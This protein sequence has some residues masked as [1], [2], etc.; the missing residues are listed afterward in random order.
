LLD[1]AKRKQAARH[2][3]DE[4]ELLSHASDESFARH[5]L[6]VGDFLYGGRAAGYFDPRSAWKRARPLEPRAYE[7]LRKR[8]RRG[9]LGCV[10][11]WEELEPSLEAFVAHA[12]RRRLGRASLTRLQLILRARR[13]RLEERAAPMPSW[14]VAGVTTSL[15]DARITAGL[16]TAT[17]T[18]VSYP[19]PGSSSAQRDAA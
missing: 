11:A 12:A 10:Q 6:E 18:L 15:R 2:L 13:A 5:F 9:D 16:G 3:V 17:R 8:V 4:V 14:A 7:R 19:I 1:V